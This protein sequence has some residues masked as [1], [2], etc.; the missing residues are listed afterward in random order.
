MNPLAQGC[1]H[2]LQSQELADMQFVLVN[3]TDTSPASD[4]A[5]NPLSEPPSDV[6]LRGHR[7][8]SC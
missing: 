1:Y 8:E 2:L 5:R 4:P 3:P 7:F 6:I